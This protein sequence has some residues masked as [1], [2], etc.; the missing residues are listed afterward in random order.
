LQLF[1]NIEREIE[2]IRKEKDGKERDKVIEV[3]DKAHDFLM[4]MVAYSKK[5]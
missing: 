4:A 3:F 2:K 1:N 5:S